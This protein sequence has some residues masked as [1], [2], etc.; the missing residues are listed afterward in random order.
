MQLPPASTVHYCGYIRRSKLEMSEVVLK[1]LKYVGVALLNHP[2]DSTATFGSINRKS[3]A[4]H[5]ARSLIQVV[6]LITIVELHAEQFLNH[7]VLQLDHRLSSKI[8]I[9]LLQLSNVLPVTIITL[10][11]FYSRN[12]ILVLYYNL[13]FELKHS[14]PLSFEGK[15]LLAVGTMLSFLCFTV[16][17]SAALYLQL[18]ATWNYPSCNFT[19]VPCN[20]SAIKALFIFSLMWPSILNLY[21]WNWI[22]YYGAV[23]VNRFDSL[24]DMLED[25]LLQ[26]DGIIQ[27][28]PS[29]HSWSDEVMSAV[30]KFQHIQADFA[31]YSKIGGAYSLAVLIYLV[32]QCIALVKYITDG[33]ALVH[34]ED[35]YLKVYTVATIPSV[36]AIVQMGSYVTRSVRLKCFERKENELFNVPCHSR[37]RFRNTDDDCVTS[38]PA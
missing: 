4:V 8:S 21:A 22:F 28:R 19:L 35:P 18:Q 34:S 29:G 10:S 36:V 31:R 23:L 5:L 38:R 30:T 9:G 24:I 11:S 3:R 16:H 13:T 14:S 32:L 7:P 12:D 27:V 37:H 33:S 1:F 15:I 2:V 6:L 25:L 17:S 20:D 26:T